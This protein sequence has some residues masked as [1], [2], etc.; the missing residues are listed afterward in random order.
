MNLEECITVLDSGLQKLNV[1]L[2]KTD[3]FI[4]HLHHDHMGLVS[5]LATEK[6]RIYF[7]RPETAIMT[8]LASNVRWVNLLNFYIANGFPEEELRRSMANNPGYLYGP[9]RPTPFTVLSDGDRLEIGDYRFLCIE[10]PGH[11]PGHTCLYEKDKKILFSG[12]H[13][14]FDITPNITYWPELDNPLKQYLQSLDRV[15]PIDVSL[16]L[17]GHRNRQNNHRTRIKEL[18]EHH[19]IR[20]KE[21]TAALEDG[22]KTA[23]DVAPHITWQIVYK[24]W[25]QFPAVQKYFAVGETIAHLEYLVAENKVKKSKVDS[26]TMYGLI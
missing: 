4:T 15:Y 5:T 16:V 7:N 26:T 10:T 1:D 14:L 12:D 17:P 24:T 8:G 19:A 6:S 25:E 11:S 3:F 18:H 22:D 23:Y 21:A 13:I 2:K 20:L 9:K